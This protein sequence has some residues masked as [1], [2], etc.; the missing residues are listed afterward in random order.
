MNRYLKPYYILNTLLILAYPAVRIYTRRLH[1]LKEEDTW[2][3]TRENG[4]LF[5]SLTLMFIRYKKS[6]TLDHFLNSLFSIGKLCIAILMLLINIRYCLYYLLAC[7]ITFLFFRQPKFRGPSKMFTINNQ[8]QFDEMVKKKFNPVA[9]SRNPSQAV[10]NYSNT[11]MW[12]VEFFADW[13]ETC[14][15][16]KPIWI[17][18]SNKYST[19]NL[20][21]AEVNL[22]TLPE[23]AKTYNINTSAISRQLPTLILFEDGKEVIRFPPYDD[24]SQRYMRVQKYSKKDI[25]KYFDLEERYL[26]TRFSVLPTNDEQ[27]K[28]K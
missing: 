9:K 27:T 26:A 12:I 11:N 20:R 7:L 4:I 1:F 2:G 18:F 28:T 23:M 16:T 10:S 15:Y 19:K 25:A 13:A 22:S 5:T 17:E 6:A 3:Y 21:F 14:V 24:A 8:E